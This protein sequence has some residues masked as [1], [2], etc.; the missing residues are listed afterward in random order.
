MITSCGCS[1]G[2][3]TLATLKDEGGQELELAD[4]RAT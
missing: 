4:K 1:V 3:G 2:G